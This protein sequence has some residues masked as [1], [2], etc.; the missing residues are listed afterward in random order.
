MKYR[1]STNRERQAPTRKMD[2]NPQTWNLAKRM[3]ERHGQHALHGARAISAALQNAA[4]D[5]PDATC[6]DIIRAMDFLLSD[7]GGTTV[8]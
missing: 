7:D 2:R 5:G 6:H 3:L 4:C 1:Q 8:H